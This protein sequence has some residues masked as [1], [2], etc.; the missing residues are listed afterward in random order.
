MQ[1]LRTCGEMC[2]TR[3]ISKTYTRKIINSQGRK[4]ILVGYNGKYAGDV[5]R[6]VK[7]S[8]SQIVHSRDTQ[9]LNKTWGQYHE[10]N[11]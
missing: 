7:T 1:H 8:T 2:V 5:F 10:K 11:N 6:F 3:D 4:C 9:W